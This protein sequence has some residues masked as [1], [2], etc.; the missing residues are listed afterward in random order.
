MDLGTSA[1]S[2]NA[3]FE[4][5]VRQSCQ[6]FVY[7]FSPSPNCNRSIAVG[8]NLEKCSNIQP[9]SMVLVYGFYVKK[10]SQ[11][12]LITFMED[13]VVYAYLI[14]SSFTSE[15]VNFITDNDS[16]FQLGI[17]S[18]DAKSPVLPHQ[19]NEINRNVRTTSEFLNFRKGKAIVRIRAH[20]KSEEVEFE[21]LAGDSV[22][23]TGIGI[24]SVDFL[25]PTQLLEIKQG[26]YDP[27]LDKVYLSHLEQM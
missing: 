20:A 4:E 24:H 9:V 3:D 12:G 26:P 8:L 17:M 14:H 18:R 7:A 23:F 13:S 5:N 1:S 19:H 10:I 6:F 11:D 15:G 21:V 25:E 27:K 2:R 22:L 16:E